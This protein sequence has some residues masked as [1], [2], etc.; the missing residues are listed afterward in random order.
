MADGDVAGAVDTMIAA[1][2]DLARRR[3][4]PHEAH[5]ARDEARFRARALHQLATDP[6]GCWIAEA[7]GDVAGAA[8]AI[9]REGLWGLSLLV[10]DPAYQGRGIGRALLERALAHGEGARGGMIL[11]SDDPPALRRYARAG[12]DLVPAFGA[13]GRVDRAALPAG[14]PIRAGGPAD[15]ELAGAI[16]RELRGASH[17]ADLPTLLAG[18]DGM[19]V[20]PDRGFAI[21]R[22]GT[23]LLLAARDAPSARALLWGA[24]AHADADDEVVVMFLTGAQSWAIDVLLAAGLALDTS[25]GPVFLRGEVGPLAPYI[26]NGA[27]L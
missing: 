20:V 18:S 26:P 24:L 23:P 17:A 12:F 6:G 16:G 13:L 25:S 8:V 4:R 19:L 14:L 5:E 3:G 2:A 11:A 22:G 27:F 9:V 15:F 10:V 1:F 7:G 21:H